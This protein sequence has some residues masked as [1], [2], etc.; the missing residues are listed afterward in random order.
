M[1][2]DHLSSPLEALPLV[3]DG[4]S[5]AEFGPAGA[6][7]VEAW[8]HIRSILG[9]TRRG[10]GSGSNLN[11]C[12]RPLPEPAAGAKVPVWTSQRA[13]VPGEGPIVA[14]PCCPLPFGSGKGGHFIRNSTPRPVSYHV[15][16]SKFKLLVCC[17]KC[18]VDHV[19]HNWSLK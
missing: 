14:S 4:R 13:V 6:G 11:P 8:V 5:G 17:K 1:K 2:V 12:V 15:L 7:S 9:A 16:E 19:T 10:T 3:Q 18:Q